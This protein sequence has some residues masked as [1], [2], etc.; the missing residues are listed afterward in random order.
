MILVTFSDRYPERMKR[1]GKAVI[2][3]ASGYCAKLF[4]KKR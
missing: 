1:G 2:A 3:R 4:E